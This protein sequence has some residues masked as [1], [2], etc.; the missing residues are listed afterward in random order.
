MKQFLWIALCM[1][2]FSLGFAQSPLRITDN[3]HIGWYVTQAT[4]KMSQKWDLYTEYQWRRDRW[5]SSW[6]QSQ[7]RAGVQYNLHKQVSVLAGYS[8]INTYVYGDYPIASKGYPF[9]EHRVYEQ[10]VL[11]NP[12]GRF[13]IS[14]RIRLEQRWVGQ[15][16]ALPERSVAEW[17]YTNRVRYMFRLNIPLKG[18]TLDNNEFYVGTYDEIFISFGEKVKNNI[19][20]QNRF[21]LLLGY[22]FNPMVRIEGGFFDQR[23][24]QGTPVK[25]NNV[26]EM[27][28]QNNTGL[29]A[30]AIFN[31]D[32]HALIHK[33][34]EAK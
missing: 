26:D 14:H 1:L 12:I 19:W 21:A 10:L 4:V 28:I 23:L 20:D 13:D 16:T 33:K 24:A 25:V 32:A 15:M 27:I 29:I 30:S 8:F 7:V 2:S 34:T 22:K 6:Q 3:N 5:I 17:R 11:K 9:P 18:N 31:I